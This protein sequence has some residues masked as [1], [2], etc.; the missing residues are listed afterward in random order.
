MDESSTICCLDSLP[1][2]RIVTY[3]TRCSIKICFHYYYRQ[4]KHRHGIRSQVFLWSLCWKICEP[5][6]EPKFGQPYN[7][8]TV[9]KLQ[10]RKHVSRCKTRGVQSQIARYQAQCTRYGGESGGLVSVAGRVLGSIHGLTN[11]KDLLTTQDRKGSFSNES[12]K[13]VGRYIVYPFLHVEKV[14]TKMEGSAGK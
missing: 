7:K 11:C 3:S 12:F 8:S 13:R 6:V 1:L 9:N 5:A 14:T 2:S 10:Q 4:T